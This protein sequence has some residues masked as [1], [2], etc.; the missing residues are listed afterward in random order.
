MLQ[1]LQACRTAHSNALR[2]TAQ[3]AAGLEWLRR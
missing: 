3:G 1:P 2:L